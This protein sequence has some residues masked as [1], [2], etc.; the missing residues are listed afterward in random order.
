MSPLSL[1]QAREL[2][3]LGDAPTRE[4]LEAK[5]Q[6]LLTLW[7]PQRYAGLTNNPRKYMQM[8]RKGEDM[9]RQIEAAY[10]VLAARLDDEKT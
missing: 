5:R 2:F 10:Q 9:T 1:D 8:Y 7:H 4:A 6:E 3:G